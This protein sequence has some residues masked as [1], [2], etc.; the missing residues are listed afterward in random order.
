MRA[1]SPPHR[2]CDIS[3][4]LCDFVSENIDNQL[5]LN[6]L[7][8]PFLENVELLDVDARPY[9]LLGDELHRHHSRR[10]HGRRER[11]GPRTVAVARRMRGLL[12]HAIVERLL[13]RR[14]RD[15]RLQRSPML[16]SAMTTATRS[17]GAG[18]DAQCDRC[19]ERRLCRPR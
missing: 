4:D 10:G 1:K 9:L 19:V 16:A 5:S 3:L 18:S 14:G 11:W 13:V 8:D 7:V 15:L 6:L 12:L 2:H 17:A